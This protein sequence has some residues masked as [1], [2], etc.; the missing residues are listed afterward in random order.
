MEDHQNTERWRLILG[1]QSDPS[2][3]VPLSGSAKKMDKVLEALYDSDR[4]GGLG[5]SSPN[6]NRWLGDIRRF[7]PTPVVQL[8][9][10]DALQR[11]RLE[12]KLL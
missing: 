9:Q 7:F 2:A 1:K 8:L 4:K 12:R 5:S 11:L 10:R 6:V 3:S